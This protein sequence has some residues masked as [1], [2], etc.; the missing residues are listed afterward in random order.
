MG[1]V[2]SPE[3]TEVT[4]WAFRLANAKDSVNTLKTYQREW[5]RSGMW[6]GFVLG[7]VLAAAAYGVS[8][9]L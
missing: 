1:Q 3:E 4:R 5:R 8:R 6:R 9:L 2:K 7:L